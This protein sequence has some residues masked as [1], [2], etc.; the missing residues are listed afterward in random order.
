MFTCVESMR[1]TSVIGFFIRICTRP[2]TI[3]LGNDKSLNVEPGITVAIPAYQIHHDERYY[4]QPEQFRPERF[5]NGGVNEFNKR[6]CFF[7]F[8]DGP[9]IC[10]GEFV[11]LIEL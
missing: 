3:D 8:G 1:L 9:R 7:P 2:T 10:L 4:P 11:Y 5:D 6:G